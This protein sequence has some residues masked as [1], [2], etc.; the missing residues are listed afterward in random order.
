MWGIRNAENDSIDA[1]YGKKAMIQG[2]QKPRY[3]SQMENEVLYL[4]VP[5]KAV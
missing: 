2:T 3:S 5:C 1:L 4:V